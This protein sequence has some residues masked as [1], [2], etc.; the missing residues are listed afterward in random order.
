M[1]A[2]DDAS[3]SSE[4][5][6]LLETRP[7]ADEDQDAFGVDD[8]IVLNHDD[9]KTH[10][11]GSDLHS[12]M[13][14][15]N[16]VLKEAA[17]LMADGPLQASSTKDNQQILVDE[18]DVEYSPKKSHQPIEIIVR[19]NKIVEQPASDSD[20][21]GNAERADDRSKPS[22]RLSVVHEGK[23]NGQSMSNNKAYPSSTVGK[24]AKWPRG[25]RRAW[26]MPN[27]KGDKMSL[28]VIHD[29]EIKADGNTHKRRVVRYRLHPAKKGRMN[30]GT[31][32]DREGGT[33]PTVGFKLDLGDML[34]PD[35]DDQE[36][37]VEINEEEVEIPGE[38]G[39]GS[40]DNRQKIL[41][42]PMEGHK[43][44]ASS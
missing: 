18:V 10:G 42:S 30:A 13:R 17:N 7:N 3:T 8:V 9:L 25:H 34:H 35:D 14:T 20:D 31:D 4:S 15:V 5:Q 41:G 32:G 29:K 12:P 38:S 16:E 2:C 39:K 19:H 6:S 33:A 37:E 43:F 1:D 28:A 26:S 27:A 21:E 40:E 11:E 44:R 24:E 23:Q 36:L 22:G